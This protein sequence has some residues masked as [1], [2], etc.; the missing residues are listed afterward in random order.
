MDDAAPTPPAWVYK[1]DGRQEPFDA[2]KISRALF[3]ASESLHRPDA[4]LARELTDGVVHFLIEETDGETPRTN[5]IAEVVVKVVREL[6]QP[7]LAATFAEYGSQRERG[8]SSFAG[9]PTGEEIVLHHAAGAPLE[10]VLS[11]CARKYTLQTVFARDLVAAQGDGLLTLT[12][13]ESP[14]AL[15]GCVLGPPVASVV[16]DGIL[17]AI[18]K[19]HRFAGS[20]LALDGPEYLLAHSAREPKDKVREWAR[21]LILGLRLTGR[22]AV[23]NLNSAAPPSWADELAEGPLFAGQAPRRAA[24][25]HYIGRRISTRTSASRDFRRSRANRLALVRARLCSR[26]GIAFDDDGGIRLEWS[27]A[28]VR[29]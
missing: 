19:A 13:L 17:A 20:L 24:T 16:E 26:G 15:A 28:K 7:A 8:K 9:L 21:E 14:Y 23:V 1:R 22:R 6:G 10:K 27:R 3:A 4:F 12:G 11:E 5:Q 29:L 25:A 18:E 2:D